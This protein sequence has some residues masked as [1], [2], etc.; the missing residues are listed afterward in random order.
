MELRQMI[1]ELDK[2]IA[3]NAPAMAAMSDGFAARPEVSGKEFETS[4]EIVRVLK[5]AGF[6]VEYPALGIPTAFTARCGRGGGPKV[7]ILTEYDALPEIGHACGHNLHG[8][9]SVL[10]AL[11]LL[12]IL[13]DI[14]CELLVA[15]TPA[16]ETDGAK[17]EMS[18]KGLFDGCDFA[19]MIHS[20]GGKNMVEYRSLAMDAVE[21]TFTGKTS[22]A[23]SAP[24]EGRNALNGLQL[25]GTL[26][27]LLG[28]DGKSA[29]FTPLKRYLGGDRIRLYCFGRDGAELAELRPE[30]AVQTETMEQAMRQIAP[31]VKAGDMVLLSP[32][33][34]SLDQFKNFEQR[35]EMFARL[36][37]ELG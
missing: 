16:E 23:A 4:K 11:S 10:T 26:Y 29:D 24:W 21:F 19:M 34:A 33:C 15:G 36:A 18:A 7:A 9:M 5:D 14:D 28:G 35:G 27:L 2:N 3:V 1:A 13:K 32:A 6:E 20:C 25:D 12:P 8:S 22:H 37:K 30:V 17:V 31:L